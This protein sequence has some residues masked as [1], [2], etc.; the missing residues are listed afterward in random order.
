VEGRYCPGTF[1]VIGVGGDGGLDCDFDDFL[2]HDLNSPG[3]LLCFFKRPTDPLM[4]SLDW[5]SCGPSSILFD[6]MIRPS[7]LT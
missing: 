3:R 6:A 5:T 2:D 1:G 7:K 4:L